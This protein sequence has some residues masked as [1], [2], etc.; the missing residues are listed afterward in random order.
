[1]TNYL[2]P[3]EL[4]SESEIRKAKT[5]TGDVRSILETASSFGTAGIGA[6]AASKILPLINQYIPEDLAL[7][8]INKIM[9][10][11]GNFLKQ[12]MKQ[13]LSLKSGLDF[14]KQNLQ[15]QQQDQPQEDPIIKQAKDFETSYPD[16]IKALMAKINEGQP[17][18]AAAA[19]LK[20]SAPFSQKIKK[21]EKD[22]GKNFIDFI[23]EMMG[24]NTSSQMQ[25]PN[26]GQSIPGGSAE[27]NA[28]GNL[29]TPK[30]ASGSSSPQQS[31]GLDPQLAQLMQ[32]IRGSIQNLRG[33]N[34]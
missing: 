4:A 15:P 6:K 22:T 23:L 26:Q 16:I 28:F 24:G 32:G 29:Q 9:P 27:G 14:L 33:G 7:K 5:R 10:N 34:G 20:N 25:K 13:G 2:R 19:I 8:G 3:D 18:E 11:V 30:G 21:I 12:G 1:M 31:G 17:P